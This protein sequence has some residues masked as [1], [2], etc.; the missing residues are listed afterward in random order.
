MPEI[1]EVARYVDQLN[2]KFKGSTLHNVQFIGGRFLK[3][4]QPIINFPL[5]NAQFNSKGKFIYWSFDEPVHFFITLGMTGSFGQKNNYSG[6]EF[7][8]DKDKIYFNDIRHFGTFKIANTQELYKKLNS[9]GWDPLKEPWV[10]NN[11]Y[12]KI[13]KFKNKT[14]AEVLLNQKI[15]CGVGNYIRSEVLYKAKINPLSLVKDLDELQI[16]N[17]CQEIIKIAKLAYIA[18]GNTFSTYVDM[19]GNSGNFKFELEVYQQKN[20]SLGNLVERIVAP[21]GR[22]IYYVKEIQ[23]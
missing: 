5:N 23:K 16:E 6:I 17:L 10:P 4:K 15:F 14:I 19:Y 12:K 21:D 3:E 11:I 1:A 9:L 2:D 22:S 20:D 18:G 8:F 13:F 7:Q